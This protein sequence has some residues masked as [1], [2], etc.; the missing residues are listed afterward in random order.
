MSTKRFVALL[1]SCFLLAGALL[2]AACDGDAEE[3]ASG[4]LLVNPGFEEGADP[5]YSMETRG[6]GEPFE[7]SEDVAHSGARSALLKLRPPSEPAQHR[8]FGVVQSLKPDSFPEFLSGF[9]RVENWRKD[10]PFQY[11]QFVVIAF[12]KGGQGNIQIRYLLAGADAEPFEISN[13]R[14]VF[15]GKDEPR[16][17][18]WVYFERDVAQDFRELWGEVPQELDELRVFFEAR[19]DAP[20]LITG[21]M[22]GDVYYDDLYLGSKAGAPSHP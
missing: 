11:L 1:L 21:E 8:V 13:A 3:G 6:W 20:G 10:A 12:P 22:H 4:N 16:T 5:W 15:V 2:I 9:Y 17:G 14:F 7:I 19:Y 18:E